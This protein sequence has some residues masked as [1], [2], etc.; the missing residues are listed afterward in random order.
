MKINTPTKF[1][2]TVATM[3]LAAK[4]K[5]LWTSTIGKIVRT[6]YKSVVSAPAAATN[7]SQSGARE[8]C[9][10]KPNIGMAKRTR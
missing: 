10:R 9:F 3:I 6:I 8:E 5:R 1:A 2:A 7:F 4:E